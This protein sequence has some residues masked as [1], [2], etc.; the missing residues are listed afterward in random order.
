MKAVQFKH[1]GGPE[2]LELVDLPD[3]H[4]GPGQVRI[5]V[6]AAGI[7]ASDTKIRRG[8][9]SFGA[10]LPQTTGADVAGV[11]DEIGDDV[12]DV[13]V[14]DR[15]FGISDNQAAAAE[16]AL[17]TYRAPIPPSLGFADA[18]GI[19]AALETATRGLDQLHVTAGTTLFVNGASGGVG[20]ATVQLALARGARVIGSAGARNSGFLGTLGAEPVVYGNGMTDRVRALAPDGV[21]VALDVAGNGVLPELIALAGGEA[22][23]VITV[24]DFASAEA[25]GV[26]FSNGF[27]DGNA[28][29]ALAT[30]GDLIEAGKFWLPV[31]RTYPLADIAEAHHAA[32]TGHV[33]GRLVLIVN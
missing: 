24:A 23:N 28:F 32:E 17:L 12:T 26:H 29:H 19:P 7:S 11:V 13:A 6:R 4:P 15:I 1:Y 33:R 20:T 10:T 2:V 3:P 9:L 14:G 16:Y 5:T 30:I 8:E 27:A 25:H 21:D 31:E 18:A 22:K